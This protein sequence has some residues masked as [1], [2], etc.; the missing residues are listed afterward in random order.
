MH[1]SLWLPGTLLIL[2]GMLYAEEPSNARIENTFS[3]QAFLQDLARNSRLYGRINDQPHW[4]PERCDNAPSLPIKHMS[5]SNDDA[6]HGHKLYSIF[7]KDSPQY[8]LTGKE[9]ASTKPVQVEP[10][11]R[12]PGDDNCLQ[13]LVKESW[14][15][16]LAQDRNQ[17]GEDNLLPLAHK[18]KWY[19]ASKPAGLF[20]MMQFDSKTPDT[21][22]GWVY[23]TIAADGKTVTSS[24][25]VKNCMECHRA[26]PHGRVFGLSRDKP[27]SDQ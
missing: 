2:S 12:L 3:N 1:K 11:A 17:R 26:A 21:D 24:G 22:A 18:G 16:E 25:L 27:E 14:I 15:P 20:I 13:V 9:K 5:K 19:R 4:A 10:V 6:S 7:A 23:A 8:L